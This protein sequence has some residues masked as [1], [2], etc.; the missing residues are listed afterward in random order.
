MGAY[1]NFLDT[2]EIKE[3]L[4]EGTGGIVYRAYH[5]RL[6]QDVVLKKM[7]IQGASTATK[8]QE[9]DILKRL[10]HSY[11]PQVLDFMELDGS[12]YTV[13]SYIPGKSFAQLIKEGVRF[14]Q[15]Q[16]IKW[17]IQICSALDYLHSQNP[18]VIHSDIKPANIMLTPQ[19]DICLIDF[20][21]SFYLDY[22]QVLGYTNGYTSPEQYLMATNS[23][24]QREKQGSIDE[25]TDIYSVGAT[26]YYLV[27]GRKILDFNRGIDKALVAAN[28]GDAFAQVIEKATRPN[29]KDRYHSAQEMLRGFE[30]ITKKDKRYRR[31][32]HRQIAVR[33][34]LFVMSAGFIVLGGYGIHQMKV[35]R[36]EKYNEL[37]EEQIDLQ[38]EGAYEEQEDAYKEARALLPGN[39]EAYYQNLSSLYEQEKY[40]DCIAFAD[41]DICG[42]ERLDLQ[43]ER[44]ADIYY[45]K[46]DSYFRLEDYENAVE[47]Y[48]DV[49]D[50]G[51]MEPTYYRDYAIAL[52][53]DKNE[54]EAGEILEEAIDKGLEEDSIYYAK[55]EIEKAMERFED[56]LGNSEAALTGP[57]RKT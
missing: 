29:R 31:L 27:T 20:N 11:I 9:V 14:N 38:N 7:R 10:H 8:R 44:M 12:I 50:I 47:T 19:G 53:Y 51:T 24:A 21:I 22:S 2:Y 23:G 35:E 37:V 43:Q 39:L 17:G 49:L 52:A 6:R 56:A 26:M 18:P 48:E 1:E 55:G 4:G 32:L 45:L 54:R 5:K 28:T 3:K 16:L 40:E 33:A 36:T 41:Y 34:G 57:R 42:N 13:M 30:N 46:A 15:K 25:R